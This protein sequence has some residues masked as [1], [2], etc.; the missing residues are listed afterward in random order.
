MLKLYDEV[1]VRVL[2]QLEKKS[3]FDK[4]SLFQKNT[5]LSDKFQRVIRLNTNYGFMKTIEEIL[6]LNLVGSIY[7]K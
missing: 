7:I 1:Q 5:L 6:A 2:R 4:I 3:V